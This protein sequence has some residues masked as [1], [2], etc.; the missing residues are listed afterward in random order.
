MNKQMIHSCYKNDYNYIQPPNLFLLKRRT[1]SLHNIE[2]ANHLLYHYI[3]DHFLHNISSYELN[4]SLPFSQLGDDR[5]CY[6]PPRLL[7]EALGEKL[8]T[9]GFE[10][11]SYDVENHDGALHVKHKGIQFP[12]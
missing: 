10:E 7:E 11:W 8:Q 2:N 9:G 1:N 3:S 4:Q 12:K 5:G 6:S